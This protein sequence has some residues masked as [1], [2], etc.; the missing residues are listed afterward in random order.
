MRLSMFSIG[1]R[2]RNL[3]TS[4]NPRLFSVT[5]FFR[6]RLDLFIHYETF[7]IPS[8]CYCGPG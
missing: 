6:D 1:P 7:P 4:A 5:V 2:G 8:P 3:R